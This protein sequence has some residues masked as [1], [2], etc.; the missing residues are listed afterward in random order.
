MNLNKCF[1][2]KIFNSTVISSCQNMQPSTA[3][4]VQ[5]IVIH[6]NSEKLLAMII[7]LFVY[8]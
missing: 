4:F 5:N 7:K 6:D 2:L 3:V 8:K 1:N